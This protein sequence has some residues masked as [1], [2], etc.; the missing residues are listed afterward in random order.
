MSGPAR[1]IALDLVYRPA[2]GR[3]HFLVSPE[4]ED[5][6][7]IIDAWRDWPSRRLAL[8]GPPASGKTHLAHVWL[9]E[10]GG[11]KVSASDLT[12]EDA[13][14]FASARAVLVEDADRI[15]SAS[16][17]R[18]AE[19]GLFHLFNLLGE[20]G[21]FLLVTGCDSPRNWRIG[22]PDLASRLQA[23]TVARIALPDD[24]LLSSILV[25]LFA[26]RQL[27]VGPEVVKY[28][29]QRIDRSFAAARD[30]VTSLDRLSLERKRPISRALASV[31]L[32]ETGL[33]L[34]D[35]PEIDRGE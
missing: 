16:D 1:Q 11:V 27:Q 12:A 21:G 18:G 14:R 31:W 7:R 17:P 29:S 10:S 24:T 3:E 19:E 33:E 5:A 28:L 22:L 23:L 8:T 13:P 30:A 25:K 32:R 35:E 2:R 6:V 15:A 20:E 34:A 4:N 26:D 9:A